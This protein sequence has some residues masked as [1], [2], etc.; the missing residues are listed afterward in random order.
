MSRRTG[1]E[2]LD[3]VTSDLCFA[4]RG[5]TLE[6]LFEVAAEALLAATLENP[7]SVA[8]R[9][10]RSL[11][12][13]EPDLE[14]L[15]LGFLNELVYLRDAHELLLRPKRLRIRREG[16]P[17]LEAQLVGERLDPARHHMTVEVKAVTAHGLHV[18]PSAGAWEAR[19]TLDV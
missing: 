12:I 13:E 14:L 6:G 1:Y 11:V 10:E 7:E 4:A 5:D 8:E 15:M 3:A 16:N 19:V 9:E 2:F 17:R 18:A